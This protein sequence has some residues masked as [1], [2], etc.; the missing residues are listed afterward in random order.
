MKGMISLIRRNGKY[1]LV[2]LVLA[3]SAAIVNAASG[4]VPHQFSAGTTAKASQVNANFKHLTDRSW[5]LAD[6]ANPTTSALYH[7]GSNVGI[8]TMTP[9]V[10]LEV[11]GTVKATAFEGDGALS[12]GGTGNV[13]IGT[14]SPGAK[15]DVIGNIY[16]G[17]DSFASVGKFVSGGAKFTNLVYNVHGTSVFSSNLYVDDSDNLK[18]ANTHTTIA[19]A[20]IKIPGNL[21]P[22]QNYI[23]FWTTPT[24]SVT[25][26]AVYAPSDPRMVI[27]TGGNVGIG[28]TS[29]GSPLEIKTGAGGTATV[30]RITNYGA[31]TNTRL[32]FG[33]GGSSSGSHLAAIE[34]DN[35]S[36]GDTALRFYTYKGSATE[37]APTE[38]MVIDADG[39][40]GIG[41]ASPNNIL[42]IYGVG[43]VTIRNFGEADI[44]FLDTQSNQNWQ[45]GTNSIGWYVY[46]T[47]Y[48]LVIKKGTGNVGIGTTS[49][50]HPLHMGSG[51]HVT[52]G[53]VWTNASSIEYKENVKELSPKDALKTLYALAPVRFSYKNEPG[54]EYIGFIAEDVPDLVATKDRK[55]LSPMDIVAVLTK[56]VKEQ[57]EIINEKDSRLAQ[58]EEKVSKFAEMEARLAKF[59][60]A[61]DKLETLTARVGE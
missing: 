32:T 4:P 35:Y 36:G 37:A 6:P 41:T 27:D 31:G 60:A 19:G 25:S 2:V 17:A 57:Q 10:E 58:L 54:E 43:P 1:L 30:L 40:V 34:G 47:A 49:P 20:A 16:A 48:R 52:S 14:S 61:L 45:A 21:R 51:A 59:E 18:V 26:D 42:D 8:G 38:K 3:I 53:G 22:R 33:S 39:N 7:S 44:N 13:G 23:E 24:G 55:G 5:E 50:G 29:P 15:L 12:L 46:D 56:V 9:S 28:T 11:A